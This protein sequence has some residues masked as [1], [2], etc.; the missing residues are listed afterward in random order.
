MD[1]ASA[2]VELISPDKII[3]NPDNPRLIFREAE[4]DRLLNSIKQVGI[5]VPLTVYWDSRKRRYV[6]MDGERRW[7]CSARLNLAAVP[8]IIQPRPTKLENILR[9]FNIHNVREQWDLLPT[10]Y[11]LKEV[12][13]LMT[14]EQKREPTLPELATATGVSTTTVRRAFALLEIPKKYLG[15]LMK[16]LHKPKSEQR[17]SEDFF[18]EVMKGLATI[19]KYTPEVYQDV[20]KPEL[21]DAFVNKY[22]RKVITNIVRFRDISRI[23]RAE[24]A[25][26]SK[27]SAVTVLVRL[28]KDP[29]Y[30]LEEAF[31]DS[32]STA[33]EARDLTSRVIA[34][35]DRLSKFPRKRSMDPKL[36]ELL[37]NLRVTIET[38]LSQ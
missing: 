9:M 25:G 22:Q 23:A 2:R 30:S 6:L 19:N 7:M 20:S 5:Q 21:I 36:R 28:G 4:L 33:Y 29:E 35:T 15:Q 27:K 18:L 8:V 1:Q 37:L 32:V 11:K 31:A 26:V 16:E 34:L 10:A 38:L 24:K 12:R 14:Q 17:L 3:R 13:A